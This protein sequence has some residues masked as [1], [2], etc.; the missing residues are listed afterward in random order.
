MA[1]N[2]K[3]SGDLFASGNDE[4]RSGNSQQDSSLK[5]AVYF[6]KPLN[7]FLPHH[8]CTWSLSLRLGS[9]ETFTIQE[10]NNRL[11]VRLKD[12]GR[13][14]FADDCDRQDCGKG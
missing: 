3:D 8:A 6:Q 12:S 11:K 14:V 5:K 13:R 1:F 4:Q 2:T 7:K 9:S 10:L